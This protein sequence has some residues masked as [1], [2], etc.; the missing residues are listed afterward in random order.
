MTDIQ[1]VVSSAGS[2]DRR[3]HAY[4]ARDRELLAQWGPPP[5]ERLAFGAAATVLSFRTNSH[6]VED[7]ID[8]HASTD[9]PIYRLAFS[10]PDMLSAAD[11]PRFVG[12]LSASDS[13][14]VPQNTRP[15]VAASLVDKDE[16]L[17]RLLIASWMPATARTLHADV[18]PQ[19]L[20][21]E[22]ITFWAAKQAAAGCVATGPTSSGDAR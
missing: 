14:A 16:L 13:R 4:P 7:L 5:D 11:V 12:L 21:E 17:A 20:A 9:D 15:S 19:L 10:P 2:A 8:W 3:F 6:V 18:P 1:Q 22:L